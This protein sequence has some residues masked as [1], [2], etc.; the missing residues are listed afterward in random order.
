MGAAEL[1][2]GEVFGSDATRLGRDPWETAELTRAMLRKAFAYAKKLGIRTGI[3]FE[4]YQIPD[5][6]LRA[7][8][9]EANPPG[10]P[11]AHR[12]GQGLT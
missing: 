1:Y 8:P 3:G 6:I 11:I 2:D 4:P 5:E 7:L 9:P 12:Q 10:N